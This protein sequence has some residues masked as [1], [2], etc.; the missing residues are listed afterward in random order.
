M[1]VL[2]GGDRSP[3]GVELLLLATASNKSTSR[4]GSVLE[5]VVLTMKVQL[6]DARTKTVSV[7]DSMT[8]AGQGASIDAAFAVASERCLRK[9]VV[10]LNKE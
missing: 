10:F 2:P 8:H 1:S 4:G 5:S 9:V 3:W 7:R 6:I